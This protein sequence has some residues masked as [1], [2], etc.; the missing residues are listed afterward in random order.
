MAVRI[1]ENDFDI[2]S[3]N[4]VAPHPL[5]AWEWG[6]A[7]KKMGIEVHRIGEFEDGKLVDVFQFTLHPIPYTKNKIGYLP[8]SLAPSKEILEYLYEFGAKNKIIFFKIEPYVENFET[9]FKFNILKSKY[10]LFPTW[11]QVLD[12]TKSEEELLKSMKPKTRYNIKLAQKKG[13]TVKEMS[14]D[15]GFNIFSHLY[16]ETCNRQQYFG[17][18]LKYHK[19]VWETLKNNIAHILIAFY[20]GEPLASFEFFYLNEQFYYPYGGT[21]LHHRNLMASNLLMWEAIRLGHKLGAK[22]FDMWGSLPPNYESTNDW[23][24][25]TRFKEGYGTKFVQLA[26]SYDLIINQ[27]GY[28]IYSFLY[29]LRNFYLRLKA[30]FSFRKS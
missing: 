8:R 12:L 9:K 16:F 1:I 27:L 3:Y 18:N 6:Q 23:A 20:N 30:K 10:P 13:V 19:V 11:T 15:E 22:K 25:F 29:Q 5:Q 14:D 24:G 17:H 7:R 26:G 21:S 2:V 28:S 4:K